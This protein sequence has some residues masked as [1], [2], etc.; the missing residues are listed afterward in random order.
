MLTV[1]LVTGT[2][3][4]CLQQIELAVKQH[5]SCD[6]TTELTKLERGS[7][8]EYYVTVKDTSTASQV[9][10]QT[11]LRPIHSLLE[12]LTRSSLSNGMI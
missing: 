3:S 4:Y 1:L 2:A 11:L 7:T 9:Q 6:W 10:T 8:I 12:I 5:L